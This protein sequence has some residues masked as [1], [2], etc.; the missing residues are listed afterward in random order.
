MNKKD[1]KHAA[2]SILVGATVSF[3]TVLLQ[4]LIDVLHQI[5]TELPGMGVSM[6]IYLKSSAS[7][8]IA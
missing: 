1:L 3:L 8:F 2:I 6:L 5:P 7:N 4:G